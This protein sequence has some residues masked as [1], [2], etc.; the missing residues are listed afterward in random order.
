MKGAFLG[1][2]AAALLVG[3][4]AGSAR[5]GSSAAVTA[6][7]APPDHLFDRDI[8]ATPDWR[9]GEP[10]V[11]VNPTNPADVVMVWPEENAT[12]L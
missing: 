1:A 2:A 3:A 12:G 10:E 4:T 7:A 8:S 9:G 11:A 5:A 6:R